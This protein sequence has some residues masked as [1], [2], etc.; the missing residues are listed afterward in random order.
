MTR[1]ANLLSADLDELARDIRSLLASSREERLDGPV[2]ASL[3]D[4]REGRAGIALICGLAYS[5][6]HDAEPDRFAAVAAP[7]VDDRRSNDAPVYFSEVVVPA[8]NAARCLQDL[9]GSRFVY[10]EEISFSGYRAMEHELNTRGWSWDFFSERVHTAS[11]GKSLERIMQG[12][13]DAAAVDSHVL[14]LANRRDPELGGHI[15][16]IESLGPYPAP[17]IAVNM[18]ACDLSVE[19]L[20]ELLNRLPAECLHRAAIRS[21]QPVD[22]AYYDTIR[23]VTRDLPGLQAGF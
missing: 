17:P 23:A 10:N 20:H 1:V 16:V 8:R 22:D 13:A 15:K 12:E 5:L 21:W 7:V 2:P 19:R 6:L 9:S 14:L 4:F 11:H 18:S 3:A